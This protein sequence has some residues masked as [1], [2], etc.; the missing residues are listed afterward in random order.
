VA[1]SE[2]RVDGLAVDIEATDLVD[3]AERNRRVLE[4]SDQVRAVVGEEKVL[5]AITLSTVHTQVVNPA[6]W[7]GYPY[8][9]LARRYDV[10]LPMA[11]WTLRVGELS[12]ADRYV[13]ENLDRL[14]AVVGDDV[15]IHAIGGLA[16]DTS[17][18]DL[19]GMLSAIDERE[20]IGG[21]LYDWAT[22]TPE[23]WEVLQPLRLLRAYATL[24][25]I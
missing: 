22:S 11:Y 14:R 23:Q 4:L 5:A 17:V 1:A 20:A 2:L 25:E 6:F 12:A 21:S 13:G 8:A 15:P 24:L 19:V 10:I 7:P 9:E 3:V 16:E 18:D